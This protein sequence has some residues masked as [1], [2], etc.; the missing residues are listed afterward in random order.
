MNFQF[1]HP[2]FLWLLIPAIAWVLW[3][4]IKSDAGTTR[5]RKWLAFCDLCVSR[6]PKERDL[7]GRTEMLP[8][9]QVSGSR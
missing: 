3:L 4:T 9:V 2:H 5:F 1:T 8:S 6:T 7:P